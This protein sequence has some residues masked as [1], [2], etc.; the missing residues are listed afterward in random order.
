MKRHFE[1]IYILKIILSFPSLPILSPSLFIVRRGEPPIAGECRPRRMR[2]FMVSS[3]ALLALRSGTGW[4]DEVNGSALWQDRIFH[5]LALLYGLLSA[6]ALVIPL[7][8]F[9]FNFISRSCALGFRFL[10][11][12][13]GVCWNGK[14]D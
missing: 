6:I 12:N 10:I 5:T 8:P 11:L 2:R 9:C 7:P 3:P 13:S 1:K 14:F 4:S